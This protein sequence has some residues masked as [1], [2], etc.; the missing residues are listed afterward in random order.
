SFGNLQVSPVQKTVRLITSNL[1]NS[2]CRTGNTGRT[3]SRNTDV[4]GYALRRTI[5]PYPSAFL[6]NSRGIC[7]RN[8]GWTMFVDKLWLATLTKDEDNA[9]TDAGRLTLTVNF[10]GED[11]VDTEADFMEGSGWLSGG[12]GPD[13][14]WLSDGEGA[15]TD[16]PIGSP[17]E[18]S[19]L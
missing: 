5:R 7:A 11:V 6:Q 15:L 17:F 1:K 8:G 2:D 10:D 14:A 3:A 12:L 9:G 13:H 4:V 18:S 16:V 19:L